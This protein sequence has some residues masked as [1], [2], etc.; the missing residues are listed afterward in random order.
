VAC[1]SCFYFSSIALQVEQQDPGHLGPEIVPKGCKDEV[2]PAL[3]TC[4]SLSDGH[5]PLNDSRV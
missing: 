3:A 1:K 4:A 5:S 2:L